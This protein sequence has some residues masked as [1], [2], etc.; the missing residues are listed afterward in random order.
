MCRRYRRPPVLQ[1][2]SVT[3]TR[4]LLGRR[5]VPDTRRQHNVPRTSSPD[6]PLISSCLQATYHRLSLSLIS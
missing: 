3:A 1:R 6:N 4:P 5:G 2:H